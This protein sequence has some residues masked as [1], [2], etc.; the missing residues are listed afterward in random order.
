M[1]N[2]DCSVYTC[3]FALSI[4]EC[5]DYLYNMESVLR[6]VKSDSLQK[7]LTLLVLVLT[8]MQ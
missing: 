4:Y 3:Q 7:S 1:N 2:F 5:C 6:T 8:Y